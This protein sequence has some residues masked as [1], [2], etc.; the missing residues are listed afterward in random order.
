ML[1]PVSRYLQHTISIAQHISNL[2]SSILLYGNNDVICTLCWL[3]RIVL[4]TRVY[5]IVLDRLDL[6]HS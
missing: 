4:L 2:A 5:E 3:H 1:Q 6:L